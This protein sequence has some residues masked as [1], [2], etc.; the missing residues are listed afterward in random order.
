MQ[1]CGDIPACGLV[2]PP[3]PTPQGSPRLGCLALQG[4]AL[5]P[6]TNPAKKRKV[7]LFLA[8]VGHGYQGMQR[9]PG[10][11]TIEDELFRAL[12]AA[13]AISDANNDDHGFMKVRGCGA[14]S[15][16]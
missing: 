13:G 7:A 10:A 2:L 12:H 8:Y 6:A 3:P 1:T 11:R 14:A 9:N 15:A 5:Q 16:C 4:P